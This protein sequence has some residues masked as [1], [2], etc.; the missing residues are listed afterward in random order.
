MNDDQPCKECSRKIKVKE[1]KSGKSDEEEK[2]KVEGE[3]E[4]VEEGITLR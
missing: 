2:K 1:V 3:T 4:A